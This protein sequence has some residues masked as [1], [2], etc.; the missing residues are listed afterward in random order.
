[1]RLLEAVLLKDLVRGKGMDI[2]VDNQLVLFQGLDILVEENL[3]E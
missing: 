3:L 2:P 1:M